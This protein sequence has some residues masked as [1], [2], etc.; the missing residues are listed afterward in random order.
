MLDPTLS[1]STLLNAMPDATLVVD[2]QGKIVMCN[3]QL[4]H[5]FGYPHESLLNEPIHALIPEEYRHAH[6][7]HLQEYMHYPR[8]RMMGSVM[9]LYGQHLNGHTFPVDIMLSPLQLEEH[10]LVICSVREMREVKQMQ[11]ALTEALRRE[12][13]LARSDPL[14]HCAN[15]RAFAELTEYEI[16]R[17]R[18]YQRPFTLAFLALGNFKQV[19]V[20][21]GHIAGDQL[22]QRIATL[23]QGSVRSSDTVARIDGD[24]FALLLPEAPMEIA[25]SILDRLHAQLVDELNSQFSQVSPSMAVLV[26][27]Q[28]P[29]HLDFLLKALDSQMNELSQQHKGMLS[30]RC[31]PQQ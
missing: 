16:E 11:D 15:R 6:A 7:R 13:Q 17:C 26:C 25:Q 8:R 31:Y 5:M 27:Q 14:T 28:P 12:R 20:R 10:K 21:H 18:R 30:Y 2:G 19:N 29:E 24:E 23:L 22:L 9:T 3:R 4:E 1:L